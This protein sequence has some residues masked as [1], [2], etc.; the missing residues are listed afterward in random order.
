[1]TTLDLTKTNDPLGSGGVLGTAA[2]ELDKTQLKNKLVFKKRIETWIPKLAPEVLKD[3][4]DLQLLHDWCHAIANGGFETD[5]KQKYYEKAL[6][7]KMHNARWWTTFIR[8]LSAFARLKNPTMEWIVMVTYIVQAYAKNVFDIHFKP[9][10]TMGS[11]HYHEYLKNSEKCLRPFKEDKKVV[12]FLKK[13]LKIHF[14]NSC[15]YC[16]RWFPRIPTLEKHQREHRNA[17]IRKT[18]LFNDFIF[19]VFTRFTNSCYGNPESVLLA[20]VASDNKTIAQRG[21]EIYVKSLELHNK[22]KDIR[23]FLLKPEW[24]NVEAENF[25]DMLRWD[26]MSENDITPPPLLMGLFDTEHI[27][28]IVYGTGKLEFPNFPAHSQA[29]ERAIKQTTLSAKYN[30]THDQQQANIL[31]AKK[32][33]N[34]FPLRFKLSDFDENN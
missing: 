6:C 17:V 2:K 25:L 18:E 30:R 11:V 21:F 27:R 7:P 32:S 12:S 3:Y 4:R 16:G 31:S 9:H 28:K 15:K 8:L 13:N 19:P 34:E 10:I 29:N 14:P 1:M 20:A 23:K 24:I 33:R 5:E 22:R 26:I